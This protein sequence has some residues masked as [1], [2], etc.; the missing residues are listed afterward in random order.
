MVD[1]AYDGAWLRAD[2]ADFCSAVNAS[3]PEW[4]FVDD[5]GFPGSWAWSQYGHLSANAQARRLPDESDFDLS[6]R[7]VNEFLALWSD[8]LKDLPSSSSSSSGGAG[9]SATTTI[10]YYDTTFE[11]AQFQPN[12]FVGMPSEYGSMKDLRHFARCGNRLF[13]EPFE[14]DANEFAKTGSGHT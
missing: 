4:I 12:R 3:R 1:L 11:S 7:M 2:I 6:Y 5:E 8:C 14:N 10:G 13:F 9:S